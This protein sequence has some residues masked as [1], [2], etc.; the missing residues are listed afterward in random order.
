MDWD[1]EENDKKLIG[2]EGKPSADNER[3]RG[4]YFGQI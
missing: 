4:T 1:R 2:E 3:L